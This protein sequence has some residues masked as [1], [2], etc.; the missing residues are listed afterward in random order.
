MTSDYRFRAGFIASALFIVPLGVA[1]ESPGG[2]EDSGTDRDT[3]PRT[4]TAVDPDSSPSDGGADSGADGGSDAGTARVRDPGIAVTLS[5]P[6][7]CGMSDCYSV[8]VTCADIAEPTTAT[9]EVG[10]SS[11]SE[12][13]GTIMFFTGGDGRE[14]WRHF[15]SHALRVLGEL[16]AMG[17]VTAQ[18][19]WDDGWSNGTSVDEG[20]GKLACRPAGIARWVEANIHAPSGGDA[21]CATGNS[22]GSS[23][24]SYMITQYGLADALSQIVPSAGPPMA[25][26]DYG[27]LP[28]EAPSPQYLYG[29]SSRILDRS[30]GFTTDG[31]C[32]THD[33]TFRDR[34]IEASILGE[35][36]TYSFPTTRI[37]FVRGDMDSS[38][39][40]DQADLFIDRLMAESTP[41][42]DTRVAANT[43][44]PVPSTSEGA[45]AV[46]DALIT[47]CHPY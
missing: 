11:A 4:D 42:I 6:T 5:G 1:C 41:L 27:C 25:R 14:L 31:P 32:T 17:F 16:E 47:G 21:L 12:T 36:W 9:V 24:V 2:V 43:P 38:S 7:A 18:V 44:H 23:Q 19:A 30:Y 20:V 34:F 35:G 22:G 46:R 28:S 15:G 29:S 10:S 33:I 40:V 45:D 13:P 39:A 26:V 37:S 3:S 8:E